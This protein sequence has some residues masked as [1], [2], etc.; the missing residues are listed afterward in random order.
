VIK[1]LE[2]TV[3][4]T[5]KEECWMRIIMK[6][7][8]PVGAVSNTITSSGSMVPE[9]HFYTL[10]SH[11]PTLMRMLIQKVCTNLL[12]W[13]V[14]YVCSF[15]GIMCCCRGVAFCAQ[16]WHC[17]TMFSTSRE[18]PGHRTAVFAHSL[19]LCTPWCPEWIFSSVALEWL[20][21]NNSFLIE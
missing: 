9:S 19:H 3:L 4:A 18:S 5:T 1:G 16:V 7:A 8:A 20:W 10:D 14:W 13:R 6:A 15:V 21:N 11:L 2:A 12:P 17:W